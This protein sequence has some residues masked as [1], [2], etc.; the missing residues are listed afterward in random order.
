MVSYI[1]IENIFTHKNIRDYQYNDDNTRGT[2]YQY[3]RTVKGG[4]GLEF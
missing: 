2:I 1:E 3:S 4:V